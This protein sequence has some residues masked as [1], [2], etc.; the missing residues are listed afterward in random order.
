LNVHV[1][2]VRMNQLIEHLRDGVV[3]TLNPNQCYYL[4]RNRDY[5][6]AHR[7]ADF[8]TS[9]SKYVYWGLK[10]LGR[11]IPE[12]VSGSDLVPRFCDY[13]AA[14]NTGV[15]V[16]FLGAAP[17]IA[18]RARQRTNAR[19]G[20]EI[21]IGS[22]SPSMKFG[23]DEA[24]MDQIC[25]LINKSG[26]SAVV[27]GVSAPKQ[28]IIIQ[29]YKHRMPGVRVWFGVG[30]TLDYEADAVKRAPRWMTRN[31][32]EWVYRITTEPKRYW[33]R[34]VRDMGYFGLLIVDRFGRYRDPMR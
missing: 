28:E 4:Q 32:L 18:E 1:D 24:E 2:G 19:C 20:K 9:D 7:R 21:V 17:G 26:A 34:Y 8:V 11:P 5:Y 33:R 13:H 3:F 16:F 31:G 6:E 30:A 27:V 23:E 10:F 25:D 29:K 14:N 22:H 15:K 12:K